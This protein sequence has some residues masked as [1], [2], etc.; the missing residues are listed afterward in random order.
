MGPA[1]GRGPRPRISSIRVLH[2]GK[3]SAAGPMQPPGREAH[4]RPPQHWNHGQGRLLGVHRPL[5]K[6]N[7]GKPYFGVTMSQLELRPGLAD[8]PVAESA[9]SF[10]DGKRARLE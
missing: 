7:T 4:A 10:I 1:T 6:I 9:I 8:V 5:Q 3:G 2:A